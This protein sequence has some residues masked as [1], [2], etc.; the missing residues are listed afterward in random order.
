MLFLDLVTMV[1]VGLLIGTE[2]SVSVFINPI[3]LKLEDRVQ[4]SAIGLFASRLGRAMPFWYAANLALLILE[5]ALRRQEAGNSLLISSCAIWIVVIVLTLL[6]LVPIANRMA[7]MNP[8][9]FSETARRDY[10]RWDT[11]HR[12]RVFALVISMSCFLAGIH[13]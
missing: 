3:L 10:D 9:W 2:F 12:V 8:D 1:S 13:I 4:A 11:L 6:F 7:R 5:A